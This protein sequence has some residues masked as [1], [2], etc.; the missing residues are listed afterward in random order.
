M[1]HK[2]IRE[3]LIEKISPKD[4]EDRKQYRVVLARARL[5]AH[6]LHRAAVDLERAAAAAAK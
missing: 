2:S 3:R 4:T 5:S 1:K 6:R